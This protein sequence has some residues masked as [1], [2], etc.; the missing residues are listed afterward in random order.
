[1]G[2]NMKKFAFFTFFSAL[3]FVSISA[4]AQAKPVA[5]ASVD[6]QKY[7]GTWYEIARLPNKYQKKCVGN[8]TAVYSRKS[9][10]DLG[11]VNQCIGSDG[12]TQSYKSDAKVM[13]KTTNAK[14]K[15][16]WGDYWIIDLDPKYQYAAVSDSKGETLWILGRT[17]K[18]S[19]T[20]YQGILRRIETM[21]FNPGRLNKTPQ[22][23]EVI[24][25]AV[26]EKP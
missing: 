7:A 14:L 11:V 26:I 4:A 6:L 23:V 12:L 10:G 21:G 2:M 9:D 3:L 18:M 5:V 22:N 8:T 24:K 13:D 15:G 19:D 1:M 17:A 20:V 25:G 16:G